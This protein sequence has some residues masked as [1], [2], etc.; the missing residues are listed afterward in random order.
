MTVRAFGKLADASSR[1][2]KKAEAVLD[3]VAKVRSSLVM[4]DLECD[5]VILEMFRQFLKVIRYR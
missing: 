2:Y 4:L 5:D 1:S 3:T